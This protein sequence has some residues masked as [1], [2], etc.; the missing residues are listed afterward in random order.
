MNLFLE[1]AMDLAGAIQP[2]ELCRVGQANG[3][4]IRHVQLIKG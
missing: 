3:L 1:S 4:R 2:N